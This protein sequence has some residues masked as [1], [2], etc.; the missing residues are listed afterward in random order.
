MLVLSA[1]MVS[2]SPG[3]TVLLYGANLDQGRDFAIS[4]ALERGWH[5][6]S[7]APDEVTF[8]QDLEG[9]EGADAPGPSRLI[10]VFARF[11]RESGGIRVQLTAKEIESPGR[12][13]ER[14]SDVTD[15]YG[16]NLANALSS[17]RARG[18]SGLPAAA[19]WAG[20]PPPTQG[21]VSSGLHET[22]PLGPM[23]TWAYYAESYAESRGCLLSD[24][25]ARLESA[26]A[27][28]ERHGVHCEDG[29]VL[30]VYCR[31]GDCTAAPH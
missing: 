15:R 20:D 6:V 16:L 28:W 2:A 1:A 21:A 29:R 5:L 14:S 4:S 19:P 18:D 13:E 22:E 10:R 17:L 12:A 23:G 26:G 9:S 24:S 25:G 27:D 31:F 8:E 11:S 7:L 30:Q 3:P